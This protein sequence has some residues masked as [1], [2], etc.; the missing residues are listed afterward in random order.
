MWLV[1]WMTQHHN[2][3]KEHTSLAEHSAT[4]YLGVF[5]AGGVT[6]LLT[7]NQTFALSKM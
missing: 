2:P 1:N 4:V 6:V 5:V 7:V 3:M